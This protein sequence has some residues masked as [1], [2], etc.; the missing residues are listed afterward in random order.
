[1][2][3]P[4]PAPGTI[5]WMDLT[6]DDAPGIR[7]FYSK[8]AGWTPSDVPMGDYDDYCV[9]PADDDPVAGI[10]HKR[11]SNAQIPSQWMMYIVVENLDSALAACTKAGG[12]I[13][14]PTRNMGV[15]NYAV[16]RDPAGAVCALYQP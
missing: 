15:A 2:S 14:V 1:M 10:C 12:E 5:G 16:I 3:D 4:K 8:V 13:I 7:D 11:G 6:V 9:G